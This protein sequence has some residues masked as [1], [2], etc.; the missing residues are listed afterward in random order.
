MGL[1]YALGDRVQIVNYGHWLLSDRKMNYPLLDRRDEMYVY[2]I[3]PELVGKTG[4][5][6]KFNHDHTKAS[7]LF[8]DGRSI[9][10]FSEFQLQPICS[11]QVAC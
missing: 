6:E 2:D 10:W 3:N 1:N 7:I 4:A 9:A 11:V 8:D 5:I